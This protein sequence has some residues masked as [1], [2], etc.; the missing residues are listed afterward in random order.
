MKDIMSKTINL[1]LFKEFYDAE[2]I[3][4]IK[5]MKLVNG[6]AGNAFDE[7]FYAWFTKVFL[8]K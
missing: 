7:V 1:E 6:T 3:K 5:N 4:F 8:A 2:R